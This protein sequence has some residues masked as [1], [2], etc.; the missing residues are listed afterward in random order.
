LKQQ[1]SQRYPDDR[2]ASTEGKTG[3]SWRSCARRD[4]ATATGRD[5][6]GESA[7]RVMLSATTGIR[8]DKP[9]GRETVVGFDDAC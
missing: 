6:E 5:R 7:I 3:S 9:A 1:L 8:T 4:C 2:D